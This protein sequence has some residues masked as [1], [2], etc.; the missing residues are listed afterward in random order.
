MRSSLVS[1]LVTAGAVCLTMAAGALVAPQSAGAESITR[2]GA[3]GGNSGTPTSKSPTTSGGVGRMA[4]AYYGTP[5]SGL[6]WHSGFWPGVSMSATRTAQAEQWAGRPFDFVTVYPGYG[7]W[8][9]LDAST[10]VY[11]LMKGY[12][13]RLAY[14]LPLLPSNRVGQWNDVLSG[15]HDASFRKIARDLRT[16]GFG[17]T[18]IRVGLEANGDWFAWGATAS[19]APKFRAAFQRVV[20]I[21]NTETPSLTFWFDTSSGF[22]LPGQTNR[23]DALTKLYPGDAFVDGISMDHYD[24]W[25]LVAKS[26]AAFA[27]AMR[28]RGGPGLGDAADFARKRNKAFAVPEWGVVGNQWGGGDNAFFIKKMHAF[29]MSY[30]DVL[31]YEC[32]FS[33]PAS[34][35]K[36]A[37]FGP[38][39]MPKAAAAYKTYF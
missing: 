30:R 39:Q 31:V 32:Y 2:T 35:I 29:F 7:S 1:K 25:E 4:K 34:Y 28:P 5:R 21:M 16:N 9:E 3:V 8:A 26:D 12:K 18:A 27:K 22:G 10:W 33:E 20:K 17:D 38:V 13:G 14:G 11:G 15:A 6:P 19:T 36:N 24:H 37:L 23:L